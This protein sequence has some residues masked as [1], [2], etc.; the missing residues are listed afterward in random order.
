MTLGLIVPLTARQV[1]NSPQVTEEDL[2]PTR[3][4]DHRLIGAA[5]AFAVWILLSLACLALVI[6]RYKG[7]ESPRLLAMRGCQLLKVADW[8]W[9][10]L[11]GIIIPV[12][13]V[14]SISWFTPA[15][16]SGQSVKTTLR[17]PLV[18]LPAAH[19][20][21]LFLMLIILPVVIARWRLSVRARAFGFP[22]V[23]WVGLAVV[24]GLVCYVVGYL[25]VHWVLMNVA[26]Y[27]AVLWLMV[28]VGFG[29]F[30][31]PTGLL[32]RL[33]IGRM[34]LPAYLLGMVCMTGVSAAS[35]ASYQEWFRKDD[36]MK[37][38]A[39]APAMIPYEY[40]VAK[41]LREEV[42]AILQMD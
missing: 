4:M 1:M 9:V 15:G 27:A 41:Q 25:Y 38:S 20:L 7:S 11:V 33:M 17:E 10:L 19:Y 3:M 14:V 30:G 37:L 16:G 31:R 26:L 29:L 39:E 23:S 8:V 42:D 40:K 6:R 5:S 34:I 21:A 28:M 18:C 35:M 2:K 24:A 22:G 12:V 13:V 36:F 32:R